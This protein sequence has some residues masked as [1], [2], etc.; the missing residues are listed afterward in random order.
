[1]VLGGNPLFVSLFFTPYRPDGT[2][3]ELVKLETL[4]FLVKRMDQKGQQQ[5]R[6]VGSRLEN[7]PVAKDALVRLLKVHIF[8]FVFQF[9]VAVVTL[10]FFLFACR[11]K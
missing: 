10:L 7:P 8:G 3:K 1:M 4:P 6:E 9:V 11:E 5:L 2:V